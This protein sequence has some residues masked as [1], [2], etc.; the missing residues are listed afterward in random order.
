V[1]N[2]PQKY[3]PVPGACRSHQPLAQHSAGLNIDSQ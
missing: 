3:F 2:L 1:L